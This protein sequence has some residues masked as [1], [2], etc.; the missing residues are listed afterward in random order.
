MSGEFVICKICGSKLK[1]I[2]QNHLTHKHN[3][4]RL[5]EYVEKYPNSELL[6][7]SLRSKLKENNPMKQQVHIDKIIQTKLRRY[8]TLSVNVEKRLQTWYENGQDIKLSERMKM[9]NPT[10]YK[11]VRDKISSSLKTTYRDNPEL[12]ESKK[13]TGFSMLRKQGKYRSIMEQKGLWTPESKK[14]EKTIY[15]E[16]VEAWTEWSYQNYFNNIPDARKRSREYHLDHK[17]SKH[18]GFENDID[19]AVI[20]HY[21]NLEVI[22]GRLNESKHINNSIDLSDLVKLIELSEFNLPKRILLTC[23]GAAGHMNHPYEK[24]NLTFGDLKEIIT[25][26]LSGKLDIEKTVTEK[27]DGQNIFV[28]Y[29]DGQ[30]GFARNKTTIKQPMSKEELIMKFDGRGEVQQAFAKAATD[31]EAALLQIPSD[32]LDAIFKNGTVFANMEIIYPSNKNVISYDVA[33]LQF[34]DMIQFDENANPVGKSKEGAVTLQKI[35]DD[36]NAS[37][38]QTFKIIPPKHLNLK[39]VPNFEEKKN[40]LID[41]VNELENKY[42]LKDSDPVSKYHEAWW[43]QLIVDKAEELNYMIPDY[44]LNGLIRR[45][46]YLDKNAIDYKKLNQ[47][48]SNQEFFDWVKVFDKQEFKDYQKENMQPFEDIFIQLGTEVLQNIEGFLALNPKTTKSKLRKSVKQAIKDIKNTKDP[49]QLKKLY[50]QLKRIHNAGGFEKLSPAEGIVFVYK[51]D[52]YKLTGLF[53]PIN[54]LLG[55]VRYNR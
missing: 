14:S 40:E 3:N 35:I 25:L 1:Q 27:T 41:K 28:T 47:M 7:K 21:C 53:A 5:S 15:Y 44:V 37:I 54:Q 6:C 49:K 34:H 11:S 33:V 24:H 42:D 4:M 38:Q 46:A 45:W 16:A 13:Q 17:I 51:G 19:P 22:P 9:D 52:T 39:A 8:G 18:Y 30:V 50:T 2:T 10:K 36:A 23:G 32:K 48:I 26:A 20:G 43:R 31:I 55:I 12:A 29:K